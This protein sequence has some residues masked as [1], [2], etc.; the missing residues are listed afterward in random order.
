M[1]EMGD[2]FVESSKVVQHPDIVLLG[3]KFGKGKSG[4]MGSVDQRFQSFAKDNCLS[5]VY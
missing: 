2:C 1:V 3:A 4:F 5:M